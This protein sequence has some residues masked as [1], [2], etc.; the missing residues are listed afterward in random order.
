MGGFGADC[1]YT[2]WGGIQLGATGWG[3]RSLYLYTFSAGG[4]DAYEPWDFARF[5]ADAVIVNLGTNDNPVAP[6]LAWQA[7]YVAFVTDVAARY[8]SSPS[9]PAFFLAYGPMT[10]HYEPFVLNITA[11]LKSAGLNA[12]ALDL[13]LPH[14][15]TGCYGH[16]SRADNVEIAAKAKPQIAAV[17]GWGG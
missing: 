17:L 14:G 8:S 15:M 7:A 16:P 3:M 10:A 13:T 4:A 1:M 2:A 5:Q 9:A 12:T 11:T 6:A